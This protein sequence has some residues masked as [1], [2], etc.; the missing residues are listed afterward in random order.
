MFFVTNQA[1]DGVSVIDA[2]TLKETGLIGTGKGAHG[3][4]MS[5]DTRLLYVTNRLAGT[6][7]LAPEPRKH[8]VLPFSLTAVS[9]A[10][11]SA[12]RSVSGARSIRPCCRAKSRSPYRVNSPTVAEIA[13]QRGCIVVL[14][15]ASR[16]P[17]PVETPERLKDFSRTP[18]GHYEPTA[19]SPYDIS[20][21]APLRGKR[22][23]RPVRLP[24]LD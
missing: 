4:A 20:N 13:S 14:V 7:S 15:Q 2:T 16:P 3:L 9:R 19:V 21:C 1:R 8:T 5:R 24:L 12:G 17:A 10:S 22:E 23:N 18:A 11:H 6:I